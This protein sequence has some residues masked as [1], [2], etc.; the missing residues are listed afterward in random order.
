MRAGWIVTL[1]SALGLPLLA[2]Y[3]VF[4][5]PGFVLVFPPE[6]GRVTH[7]PFSL[8][9]SVVAAA[10][11]SGTPLLWNFLKRRDRIYRHSLILKRRH[12]PKWGYV[13]YCL[14]IIFW[15]IA[16]NR[17]DAL[18]VV[19]AYTF[20]PLWLG[21]I[22]VVNAHVHRLSNSAP[23]YK[24]P[25]K[26]ACLFLLSALFWWGFEYL[27][28]FTENWIYV[29]VEE[30]SA[31]H[32]YFHGSICFSTVLPAVYSVFRWLNCFNGLHRFFY[33]GPRAP[34][35]NSQ[36]FGLL[37]L[38]IGLSGMFGVGA[39]PQLAYAFLWMGP[40]L[41]YGGL[42][43]VIGGASG[44]SSWARGDWRWMAFWGL[45]GLICGFF[46]ELWNLG[47]LLKWEYR[48][49]FFNGWHVFE[50]PLLGYLGYLPF[51]MFCGLVTQWIFKKR[52][53]IEFSPTD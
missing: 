23:L 13:G 20:T 29:G 46:W 3:L 24:S 32:Y 14:L 34:L 37:C 18:A 38:T 51:G 42:L 49:S 53:S 27:N 25:G 48:V 4:G 15:I 47:S 44:V 5:D 41:I 50:M 12:F 26:F 7:V 11:V 31:F 33:L 8:P 19:Q 2:S 17:F 40:L 52:V 9:L 6:W 21:F 45:A 16:W 1:I 22:I 39:N 10:L 35:L 30:V 36:P 43:V 28:R